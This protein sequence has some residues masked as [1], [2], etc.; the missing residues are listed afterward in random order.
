LTRPSD[1]IAIADIVAA[2]EEPLL[3]PPCEGSDRCESDALWE[4][5]DRHIR[6]FLHSV[7]LADV[8]TG[9]VAGRTVPLAAD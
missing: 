5:L 9:R 1:T 3:D 8:A 4:E 2:V 7:T 6:R